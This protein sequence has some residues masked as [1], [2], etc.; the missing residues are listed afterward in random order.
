MIEKTNQITNDAN[1]LTKALKGDS[2]TQGGY[3]EM[4]LEMLLENSGLE[5]DVHYKL[6]KN[7]MVDDDDGTKTKRQRPD[8]IIELPQKNA[9]Y[10]R[11][12]AI[13]AQKSAELATQRALIANKKANQQTQIAQ[14]QKLMADTERERA[15]SEKIGRAHV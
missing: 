4:K 10:K 6:Q 15:L 9:E 7:F 5:K 3:G 13:E 8:A 12:L 11:I 2:K 14:K 1:E